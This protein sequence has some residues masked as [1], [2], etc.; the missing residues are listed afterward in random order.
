MLEIKDLKKTYG[1]FQLHCSLA[2]EEGCITGLIGSNGAGKSTT[3]KSIL[4][5]IRKD[6]GTVTLFGKDVRY[7]T[8]QDKENIG[9]VLSDS[10][11]SN[12][13][14]LMDIAAVLDAMY[15]NL[16][17]NEFLES[18]RRYQLPINKKIKEFSTGMKAKVK[19]LAAVSHKPRFLLLDEP[20]AGL[21]VLA[22]EDLLNVLRDYME[23]D[24]TRSILI[25]SHIST[26]LEGLCDDLYMIDKGKIVL[27]EDTDT[28][29]GKY[30]LLKVT[31]EQYENIEKQYLLRRR[32]ESYG[33]SLLT[34]EKQF[35][36][37]NHPQI[38][39]ENGNI[40]EVIAMMVKG[41]A[42]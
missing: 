38:A 27:H 23:E 8:K 13:L 16:K 26:D 37:E 33:Y 41:E 17:K 18:C 36:L 14:T 11:F 5:L 28:L 35:Y 31:K 10:G 24:E 7:L 6:G 30:G 20:T 12:Q 1:S 21:D 32:K 22:R 42:L 4:G 39:V 19:I 15:K 3:F 40:D 2:V 34:N 29:L 9:V 25:S